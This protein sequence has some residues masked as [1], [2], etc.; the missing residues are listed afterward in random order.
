VTN[1]RRRCA[2]PP[3]AGFQELLREGHCGGKAA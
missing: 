3:I 2:L 1:G